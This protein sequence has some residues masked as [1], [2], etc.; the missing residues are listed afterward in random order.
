MLSCD[1]SVHQDQPPRAERKALRWKW[2]L[3]RG[4]SMLG[5]GS[6][7]LSGIDYH[8]VVH[9]PLPLVDL[10]REVADDIIVPPCIEEIFYLP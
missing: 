6:P 3:V 8:R 1:A 5:A 9:S 7:L 10:L 4:S 2:A